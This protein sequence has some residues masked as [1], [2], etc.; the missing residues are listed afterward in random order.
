MFASKRC[1]SSRLGNP[2]GDRFGNFGRL[3]TTSHSLFI[4]PPSSHTPA[5]PAPETRAHRIHPQALPPRTATPRNPSP[6]FAPVAPLHDPKLQNRAW[7]III[8]RTMDSD[9]DDPS[10]TNSRFAH[11]HLLNAL[12]LLTF[13]VLLF[14]SLR[15]ILSSLLYVNTTE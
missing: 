7:T 11:S 14:L 13:S 9:G 12:T 15:F 10:N 1:I 6:D 2:L 3:K 8:R 5:F 4:L